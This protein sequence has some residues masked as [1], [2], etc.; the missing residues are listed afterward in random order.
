MCGRFTIRS[1]GRI[2]FDG[3]CTSNLLFE[4]RYNIAPSQT[5]WAI[6]DFGHGAELSSLSWGLVPSW[7]NDGKGFI[8]ARCETLEAKPSF[9]ESF[10]RRRC[11]IPGDGFFEWKRSGRMKQPYYFQLEDESPFAFAG[12]WDEWKEDDTSITSCAIITT[13]ANDL[14]SP[15][16]DLICTNSVKSRWFERKP[17]SDDLRFHRFL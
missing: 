4:A 14:V 16:H 3:E 9:S 6:G 12:I 15:L 5:I 1:P 17:S 10:Q 11:L 2:K 7:S 13:A 8:N